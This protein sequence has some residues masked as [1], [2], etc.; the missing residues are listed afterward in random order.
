VHLQTV[1]R[2][3]HRG[4]PIL[5]IRI[6]TAAPDAPALVLVGAVHAGESGPELIL[7][8]LRKLLGRSRTDPPLQAALGRM[9]VIAFPVVNVDERDRLL[10][11]HPTYLR[12]N[13]QGIDLNRNFPSG[14]E[15][16]ST[17]YGTSSAEPGSWTYR[18][19]APLSAIEA[20][21]L[22]D[23]LAPVPIAAL[24]SY[25]G[26]YSLCGPELQQPEGMAAVAPA[27]KDRLKEIAGA[28]FRGLSERP[29]PEGVKTSVRDAS[30][31]GSLVTWAVLAKGA[32]AFEV[33]GGGDPRLVGMKKSSPSPELLEEYQDRHAGALAAVLLLLAPAP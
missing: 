16:V 15:E 2:G 32:A 1:G 26:L 5:S 3:G 29:Y 17:K 25:H 6:G 18:G 10:A 23:A 28:F 31:G 24:L 21:A 9:A 7:P 12:L 30:P 33:E 27:V 19:P 20:K 11:G 14:W 22:H 4:L 13:P 8:A